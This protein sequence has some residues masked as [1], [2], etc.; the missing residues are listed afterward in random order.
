MSR[1]PETSRW[2]HFRAWLSRQARGRRKDTIAIIVLAIA[3]IV[4]MLG[5]FIQQKAALPAWIPLVGEEFDHITAEF[6]TAQAVTPGQGQ[7]VDIAGIEIGKVKSVALEDGHAVVGMDIEP[8]YME[9]IHPNASFLLRPK[10]GLNDMIVEVDPGSG[11]QQVEDGAHF[12][13][14][15]TEPNTN[16]D[17]FLATL[18]GDTRQYIQLLVAGGAQGIG[19]R[20]KQLSNALRRVQPFVHSVA[21]LNTVVAQRHVAIADAI[22]NF[23]LLTTELGRHDAQIKRFVTSSDAALGDFANQQASIQEALR[24][25]PAALRAGNAGLASSKRFSDAA[26]PALTALIP[27]AQALTPALKA[28]ETM[29]DETTVPIRDQIRPFTREI[30]PVLTH[31]N[32]GSDQFSKSVRSFGN[33]L[34]GFNSFLNELAYEPKG[35]KQSVLFYLPWLNH[36]FNASFNLQDA[37]GPALRSLVM[38]SCTGADLGYGAAGIK[39]FLKTLLQVTNVPRKEEIPVASNPSGKCEYKPR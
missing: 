16:L 22:H 21:K 37:G 33:A 9:L 24:E 3:G 26:Y 23:S 15:Q 4:M 38:I 27:Q 1:P 8:Q 28:T 19:G 36:N 10:T 18:D 13:L 2:A 31:A 34:G 30:R 20:G 17:A 11:D 6:S 29:F 14:A 39:P 12:T 7:S 25:F 32:E 5:I 35:S